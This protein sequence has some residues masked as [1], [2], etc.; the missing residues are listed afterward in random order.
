MSILHV[1]LEDCLIH[2]S[3]WNANRQMQMR[4]GVNALPSETKDR[5]ADPG[6]AVGRDLQQDGVGGLAE[7]QRR[8]S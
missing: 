5:S 6:T 8:C 7:R 3:S 4:S 1:L 2:E